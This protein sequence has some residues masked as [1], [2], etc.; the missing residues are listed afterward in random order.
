MPQ[1]TLRRLPGR[2]AMLRLGPGDAIPPWAAAAP[3]A[4]TSITRT[5]AELSLILPEQAV[6]EGVD[7]DRGWECLGI[8]ETFGLDVPGIASSVAAP[9][10]AAGHSVFVVATFDTDHFVVR[11]A[12]AAAATLEAAGHR[13]LPD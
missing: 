1:L 13:V 3:S 8:V 4:F 10:A 9:L 6:P 7:A 2:F 11:D 5:A 12:A